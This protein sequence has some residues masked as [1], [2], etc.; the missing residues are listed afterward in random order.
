MGMEAGVRWT[1]VAQLVV[2]V[3][4][5]PLL[6]YQILQL[7][8]ALQGDAHSN[9]YDHYLKVTELFLQRPHLRPYFY[10]AKLF[11]GDA[12]PEANE[13]LRREIDTMSETIAALLEHAAM[14]KSNLPGDSWNNCWR[15]FTV[16]RFRQSPELRTFVATNGGWYAETFCKMLESSGAVDPGE[17][18]KLGRA[19]VGGTN[20][21]RPGNARY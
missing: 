3:V 19:D 10:D 11:A 2:A 15:A 6:F 16:E 17:L 9:L 8:Q 14:Q 1:E 21:S 4:A 18:V 13:T 5:F 12:D 7:K 20:G